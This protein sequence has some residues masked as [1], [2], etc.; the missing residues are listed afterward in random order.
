MSETN[1]SMATQN[2]F[3]VGDPVWGKVK[4]FSAWPGKIILPPDGLKVKNLDIEIWD[5]P[6]IKARIVL[7]YYHS[8]YLFIYSIAPSNEENDALC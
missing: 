5:F 3:R 6:A 2:T 7:K 8:K 1:S 4:G